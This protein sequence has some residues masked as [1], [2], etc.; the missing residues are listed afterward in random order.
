[1]N[2]V[3]EGLAGLAVAATPLVEANPAAT[4]LSGATDQAAPE[5]I[6]TGLNAETNPQLS[7]ASANP[8]LTASP[9]ANPAAGNP[10]VEVLVTTLKAANAPPASPEAGSIS[11]AEATGSRVYATVMLNNYD[12]NQTIRQITPLTPAQGGDIWV[13][14]LGGP[15]GGVMTPVVDAA[16]GLTQFNLSDPGFFDG[17]CGLVQG[18]QANEQAQFQLRVWRGAVSF[19]AATERGVSEVW[20]QV[21]GRWNA[22]ALPPFPPQGP[23]LKLPGPVFI[24]QLS[25]NVALVALNNQEANQPIYYL[26]SPDLASGQ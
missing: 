7:P 18:V 14:L 15:V 25:N 24:G 13:E 8:D 12:A 4:V 3:A 26:T 20:S 1:M 5:R 9:V 2:S 17:G 22:D 10:W 11:A 16:Q 19:E 6:G 23:A 21:T